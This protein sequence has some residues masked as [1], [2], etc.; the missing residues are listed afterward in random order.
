MTRPEKPKRSPAPL[1][2]AATKA[3]R[4]ELIEA[5]RQFLVLYCEASEALRRGVK[6][7]VFPEGCF[8]PRPSFVPVPRAR[9]PG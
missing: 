4:L 2:H 7:V 3:A 6:D 8:P 1:F 9:D 5:Y